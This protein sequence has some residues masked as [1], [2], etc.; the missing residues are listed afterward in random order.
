MD[1]KEFLKSI[2][3]TATAMLPEATAAQH[4]KSRA[5]SRGIGE[6]ARSGT[7]LVLLTS[8]AFRS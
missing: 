5:W 4:A 6:T 8:L 1:M 3:R 2:I 7:W